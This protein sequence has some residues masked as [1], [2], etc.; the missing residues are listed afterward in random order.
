M[1]GRAN[2]SMSDSNSETSSILL[3]PI[4]QLANKS[5]PFGNFPSMGYSSPQDA[6]SQLRSVTPTTGKNPNDG[7]F[8]ATR[9]NFIL[10]HNSNTSLPPL[11]NTNA[12]IATRNDCNLYFGVAR[13]YA[14]SEEPP[15]RRKE[16]E[17]QER[18]EKNVNAVKVQKE[19]HEQK[20]RESEFVQQFIT[21][22]NSMTKNINIAMHQIK[23]QLGGDE[24]RK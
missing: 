15:G 5:H 3:K 22:K 1:R 4:S 14:V 7:G 23:S 12:L 2:I 11:G 9:T 16:R 10:Q 21:K 6:F 17:V 19:R 13:K 24:L 18:K 8:G 20:K